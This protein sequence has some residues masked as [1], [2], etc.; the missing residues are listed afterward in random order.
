MGK[1]SSLSKFTELFMKKYIKPQIEA[2]IVNTERILASSPQIHNKYNP[3][4]ALS[5]R[6][7]SWSYTNWY[8]EDE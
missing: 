4:E 2:L 3:N 7:E 6:R 5:E 1:S 8:R